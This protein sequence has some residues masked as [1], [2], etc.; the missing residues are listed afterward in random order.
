MGRW[1]RHLT[2]P[3]AQRVE[4]GA[5][6]RTSAPRG[7]RPPPTRGVTALRCPVAPPPPAAM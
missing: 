4:G 6:P 3:E 2:H 7:G 5:P 1:A